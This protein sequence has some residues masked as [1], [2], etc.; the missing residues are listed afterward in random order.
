MKHGRCIVGSRGSDLARAQVR[1]YLAPLRERFPE[2]TFTHRVIVEG[3]DRDRRSPLADVSAGSGGSAFSTEQEAALARG[4]VD[5]VVHSLK[6]LPTSNPPGL[7]L[8]PPPGREDVADALCGATLAGLP[9]G[10]RVGTGAA[11]R[12]GQLLAVRPDLRI[13]PIR[14]NVPPR[15]EKLATEGLDAV[16]LALAGL[17]RLGLDG[18]VGEVLPL[19]RFPP[20]PGQ[21]ALGIQ[22]RADDTA[23]RDLLAGAGD[24]RVDARVRAERAFLAELHGG[25]GVPVGGYAELGPDGN[26]RVFGQVTS[27]DGRTQISAAVSGPARQPEKLGKE[28]AAEVVAQGAHSVLDAVRHRDA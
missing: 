28:L 5:V 25:C 8:L 27:L 10:A 26:L 4:D 23:V 19:D 18:A 3:G 9:E 20:S 7:T 21:G 15:L 1:E 14:G 16:V 2:V 13:V 22:I 17:R 12:I 24:A 11:R 6:D